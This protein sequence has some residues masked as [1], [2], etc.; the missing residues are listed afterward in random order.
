M[1]TKSY[2]REMRYFEEKERMSD[3]Y[4]NMSGIKNGQ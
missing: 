1:T 4:E 2:E 3:A